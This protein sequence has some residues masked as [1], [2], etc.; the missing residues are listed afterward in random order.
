MP[1]TSSLLEQLPEN[2]DADCG[3]SSRPAGAVNARSAHMLQASLPLWLLSSLP[4]F[5]ADDFAQGSAS[6]YSYYATLFLFVATLPGAP[7]SSCY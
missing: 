1:A 6:S 4:A 7:I 5:A 3:G 2:N